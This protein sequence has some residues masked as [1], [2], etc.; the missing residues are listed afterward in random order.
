M[1]N[2]ISPQAVAAEYRAG[3]DFKASLGN[4]GLFEQSRINGRFYVGDHWYGAAFSDDKPL[5]RRNIIKRICDYKLATIS[6]SPIAVNFSAE[7]IAG[8]LVSDTERKFTRDRLT[9]GEYDFTGELDPTEISVMTEFLTNYAETSMERLKFSTLC[10]EALK[11]ACISGTGI[12]HTY[13]DGSAE[14]GLFADSSYRHPIKGDIACEVLDVENVV[15]GDPNNP[16]VQSQP[17]IIVSA[18]RDAE[19][20]LREAE[21]NG[22]S[23]EE[24]LKI[25]PDSAEYLELLAGTRGQKEPAA[26]NKVTV[27]LKFYRVTD[28]DGNTKIMCYKCTKDATVRPP[29]SLNISLYPFAKMEWEKRRSSAYGDSEITYLVPNQIAINRALSA[30]VWATMVSGM[31]IMLANGD[32]V[33]GEITNDPGQIIK[34]YGDNADVAG[35]VRY[36]EPPSFAAQMMNSVNDLAS[37]TLDDAGANEVALGNVRP[38]NAA[39]IIQ[40][41]EATLQPLQIKQSQYYTFIED[42]MRIWAEFWINLY[43][44]RKLKVQTDTGV[45][46]IPFHPERYSKLL[47]NARVDVGASTVFSTSVVVSTL[48]SLLSAGIIT[49]LQYLERIPDNIIPNKSGLIEEFKGAASDTTH[50]DEQEVLAEWQAENPELYGEFLKL[51]KER[52]RELLNAAM[53][54]GGD[55]V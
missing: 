39:A 35:A 20:I 19:D 52:Q 48:D 51:P 9:S 45:A 34:I 47:L 46:Y 38:D 7:G 12:I 27:Y 49:P 40:M 30:E 23:E 54:E 44:D 50:L 10:Y 21:K 13:W 37:N 18:R 4:K 29:F 36:I 42:V 6:A 22:I 2:K 55:A 33:E 26:N 53:S 14:T 28:E 24:R 16:D 1:K 43:G 3:T 25:R 11:N 5:V 41:R 8:N 17:Y 31:P 32:T 15:F